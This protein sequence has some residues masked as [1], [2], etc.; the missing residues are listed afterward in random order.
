M[1]D[2]KDKLRRNLLV[3]SAA[4]LAAYWVGFRIPSLSTLGGVGVIDDAHAPRVWSAA[5]VLILYLLGRFHFSDDRVEMRTEWLRDLES[6]RIR[7]MMGFARRYR[8]IAR[9]KEISQQ[10]KELAIKNSKAPS[11]SRSTSLRRFSVRD[12]TLT[13]VSRVKNRLYYQIQW[14]DDES[15]EFQDRYSNPHTDDPDGEFVDSYDLP[16]YR[17]ISVQAIAALRSLL[18]TKGSF[19]LVTPYVLSILAMSVSIGKSFGLW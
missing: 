12:T 7:R 1:D 2:T 8:V 3:A 10:E 13:K 5:A 9:N 16:Q 4:T 11:P 18:W 14:T 19:D 17:Y 15:W 6:I